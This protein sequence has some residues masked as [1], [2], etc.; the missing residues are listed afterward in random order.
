LTKEA[1]LLLVADPA[2]AE[3]KLREAMQEDPRAAEPQ[4][5]LAQLLLDGTRFDEC[6]ERIDELEKRGFLE[7]EA[8]RIKAALELHQQGASAGDVASCREELAKDPAD[9]QTQ[10]RLARALAAAEQFEEALEIGL[11]IVQSDRKGLGEEAR[12]IMVDIFRLLPD[13]SELTGTYRRKLST[14]LY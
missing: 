3:A 10:L 13:D 14:A 1:E 6:R 12:Q 5:C 9:I 4:I 8:E 11:H 7:P 2:A